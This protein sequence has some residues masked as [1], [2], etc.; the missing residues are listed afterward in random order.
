MELKFTNGCMESSMLINDRDYENIPYH[1]IRNVITIL[2]DFYKDKDLC[3][4]IIRTIIYRKG[5]FVDG[6]EC[7]ECGDF[8]ETYKL[9]V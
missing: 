8:N 4:E 7:E 6:Y 3:E 2:L 5:K 1:E 9:E